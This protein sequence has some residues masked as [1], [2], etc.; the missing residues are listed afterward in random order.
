MVAGYESYQYETIRDPRLA[1]L[2]PAQDEVLTS[3]V[4]WYAA[5]LRIEILRENRACRSPGSLALGSV[6]VGAKNA[7]LC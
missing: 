2:F 6:A 1:A 7:L 4:E 5:P 3:V